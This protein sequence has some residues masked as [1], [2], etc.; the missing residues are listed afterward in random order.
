MALILFGMILGVAF[1]YMM[2]WVFC[3][4]RSAEQRL[5]L[6]KNL[7]KTTAELEAEKNTSQAKLA[8]LNNAQ[9]E[10]EE[11]FK[12]LAADTLRDNSELFLSQTR[13]R[14]ETVMKESDG[15]MSKLLQPLADAL[16]RYEKQIHTIENA[17][18]E[19]YGGLKSQVNSLMQAQQA[20]QKETGNLV[21]ALTRPQVSGQWGELTL[22]RTVELAGMSEYC[23]FFEQ[24]SIDGGRLRPDMVVHLP[25]GREIVVDAKTPLNDYKSAAEAT[26]DEAREKYLNE[27]AR[28]T[29]S[30]MQELAGK[31]YARQFEK[32][33]D[34]TILFLP[35]EAFF[36]T[37]VLRDR[38][39][40]E[41]AMKRGVIIASPTTLVALL[42]AVAH[43]W[44]QAQIAENA[45]E[46]SEAG[47]I[48]YDR[49]AKL[50]DH[51]RNVG[52][53]LRK[54]VESYNSAAGS[55]TAR[56]VP[57]ARKLKELGATSADELADIGPVDMAP[58]LPEPPEESDAR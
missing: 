22:R 43:G 24:V 16:Q 40:L 8:V 53:A 58:N 28:K 48:L 42:L 50:L 35:G 56:F 11:K 39:L 14:L 29:R 55:L 36:S 4:K 38:D 26:S 54:A 5:E 10:F 52:A 57:Q 13:S 6:E 30:H 37:A 46:I 19:A 27:H 2:A 47:G 15:N 33:P 51:L 7:A 31:E 25:G 1:G 41:D 23:D 18:E 44:R 3:A 34:Y 17:R 12:A 21:N 9:A 32:A 20:L 45:R 49:A